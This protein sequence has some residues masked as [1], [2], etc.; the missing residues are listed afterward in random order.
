MIACMLTLLQ[1]ILLFVSAWIIIIPSLIGT[2]YYTRFDAGLRVITIHVLIACTIEIT[3]TLMGKWKLN[4]L[5][6]LHFYTLS[7]FILLYLFFDIFWRDRFPKWLLRCIAAGFVIFSLINSLFIQSI[8]VFNNYARALEAFL[9]IIF[10]LLSFYKLSMEGPDSPWAGPVAWISAG[11]LVY[12]SGAFTLFVLSNYILPMGY[13]L[14]IQIWA[15]HSFL[16]IVLY[17]SI[18]IGLWRGRMR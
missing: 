1:E 5:P 7:E 12:F 4:N 13:R 2:I 6:L 18:S 14:N 9:M 15:V 11:I 3:S 10:S 17:I 8:F 16:S